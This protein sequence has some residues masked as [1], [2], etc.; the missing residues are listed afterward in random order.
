MGLGLYGRPG[1]TPQRPARS[2]GGGRR[3]D[4][5]LRPRAL[6]A[7]R[8]ARRRPRPTTSSSPSARPRGGSRRCSQGSCDATML[9]AGNELVAE[10]AGCCPARRCGATLR[11]R[12][13][14]RSLPSSATGASTRRA[15]SSAALTRPPTRCSRG[16]STTG[17]EAAARRLGLEPTWRGGTSRGCA[18]RTDGVVPGGAVD[19]RPWPPW[20]RLRPTYL[21][22]IVDGRDV[23]AA[24]CET[25]SGLVDGADRGE[26]AAA[27]RRSG[28]SRRPRSSPP[29]TGS[30]CRRC[31]W[32][33]PSTS[34]SRWRASSTPPG[35][36][37][38]STGSASRCGGWSR[39][40]S[41][42]SRTMRLT[43]AL[44]GLF[45]VALGRDRVPAS[46]ADRPGGRRRLLRRGL[47]GQPDLPRRHR[48]RRRSASATSPG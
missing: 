3:P 11:A 25:G 38:S 34:A 16:G 36:T 12:T 41:D 39:T 18:A 10:A 48:A 22:E 7:G 37:S 23:L 6:R 14:A 29:S 28:C 32:P 35:R 4:V 17:A 9:N 31:S 40:G 5:R 13:S 44:A 24:R 33:S 45:A 26:R 8:H 27:P 1:L 21:P 15:G 42:G 2:P 47:P 30:R 43:L 46:L 19:P 20:S